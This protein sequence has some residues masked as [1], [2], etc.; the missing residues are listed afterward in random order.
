MS[1]MSTA[2]DLADSICELVSIQQPIG[3]NHL[4]L[5]VDPLRFYALKPRA[6]LGQKARNDPYPAASVFDLAVV[7]GDP[8]SNE[9][10]LVPGGVVPDEKQG[11]LAKS[12]E[13]LAVPREEL[14][15][16]GAHRTTVHEPQPSLSHLRQE[17]S[18]AGEGFRVGIVPAGLFLEEAH[19][20]SRL[21]P[22]MQTRLLE[23][24]PPSLV[25]VAQ[26][27]LRLALGNSC[28]PLES[29]F[30]LSY[31]GSG[32]SIHRLARSQCIP[33]RFKVARM[34]SP[35]T[36]LRVSPCS[37]LICAASSSIQGLLALPNSLGERCKS[38]RST[39]APSSS[40]AA[41]TSLGREEPR[42]RGFDP[43]RRTRG[44]R[45]A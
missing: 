32:P 9:L 3:L 37:K 27:P 21:G 34:V 2:E 40:K 39:S 12:F 8:I 10:A 6:L 33:S 7:G 18:I 38:S 19:R 17:E 4:P 1:L 28:Q 20:L 15:G 31:S 29:P 16:Y 42:V 24:A 14:R 5:A 43:F 11:L 36:R 23:A 30:F 26:N 44:W 22:R 13:P 41:W 35:E 45:C 25:L